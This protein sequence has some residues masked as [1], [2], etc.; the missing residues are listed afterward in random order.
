[1]MFYGAIVLVLRQTLH[2]DGRDALHTTVG[3]T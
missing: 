2:Y 3:R 1:M